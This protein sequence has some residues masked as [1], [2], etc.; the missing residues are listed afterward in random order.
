MGFSAK[1]DILDGEY[2]L[3][4]AAAEA[5]QVHTAA[6]EVEAGLHQKLASAYVEKVF[7]D[8]PVML[9][10]Q[11]AKRENADAFRSIFSRFSDA[12][13]EADAPPALATALAVLV[14]DEQ[15]FDRPSSAATGTANERSDLPSEHQQSQTDGPS[16]L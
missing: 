7:G 3:E 8:Q 4:R 10:K 13:I 15:W 2:L 9:T 6:G 5:Q 11:R 12:L 16:Q 14:E 1:Y